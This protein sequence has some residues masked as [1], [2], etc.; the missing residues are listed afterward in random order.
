MDSTAR[1]PALIFQ[2]ENGLTV[3]HPNEFW[4]DTAIRQLLGG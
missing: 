1:K 3:S 2:K 4:S